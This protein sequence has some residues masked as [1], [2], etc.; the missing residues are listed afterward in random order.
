MK[1]FMITK[2]EE[3]RIFREAVNGYGFVEVDEDYWT[4]RLGACYCTGCMVAH[5]RPTK[6]YTNGRDTLCKYQVVRLYN[7]ED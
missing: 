4:R 3:N 2:A 6:M 7:P 5:K 1:K